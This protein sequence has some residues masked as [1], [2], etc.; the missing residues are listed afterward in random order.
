MSLSLNP[1]LSFKNN[2]NEALEYYQSVLGGELQVDSFSSF[3]DM[4]PAGEEHLLMHGQLTTED[5]LVLMASDT[6]SSMPYTPPAGFPVSLSGDDEGRLQAV[7]DGLAADGTVIEP[8]AT[9]PW[10][11]MFGML[12]DKFGIAWMIAYWGGQPDAEASDA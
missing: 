3:L 8:Y 10:G 4:V 7:W 9:P 1:Y 12:T 5:G 6:P 2:A 11:G